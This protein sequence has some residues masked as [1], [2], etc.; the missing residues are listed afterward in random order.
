MR[1]LRAAVDC[2]SA[3][4]SIRDN[5]PVNCVGHAVTCGLGGVSCR[6]CF[7]PDVAAKMNFGTMNGF[8][9]SL[10]RLYQV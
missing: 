1:L 2:D 7:L 5:F 4:C 9:S 8:S 10:C 3:R 6:S